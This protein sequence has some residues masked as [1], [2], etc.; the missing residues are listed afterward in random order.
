MEVMEAMVLQMLLQVQ[1][2]FMLEVVE[3]FQIAVVIQVD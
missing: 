1:Q 2:Y 3:V